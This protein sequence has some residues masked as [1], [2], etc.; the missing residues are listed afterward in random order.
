MVN[1]LEVGVIV[2]VD[3]DVDKVVVLLVV[4]VAEVK[5]WTD[6]KEIRNWLA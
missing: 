3:G 4:N 1:M 2:E 5:R 6:T